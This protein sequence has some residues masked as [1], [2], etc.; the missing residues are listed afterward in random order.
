[1]TGNEDA[2]ALDLLVLADLHY[3]E[4][5]DHTC[6]VPARQAWFGREAVE[7]AVR[8]AVREARPDAVVLIGDL[9]DEGRAPGAER[10][11]AAIRDTLL[12][13]LMSGEIRVKDA[14]K[15]VEGI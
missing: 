8:R 1:M 7:R 4:H 5:A 15:F 14:E 11:L 3:V 13:K 9:V 6:P 12:P 2:P 10:D